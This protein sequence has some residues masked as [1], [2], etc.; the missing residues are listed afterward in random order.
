MENSQEPTTHG[1]LDFDF[2]V[3]GIYIGTNACCQDHFDSELL[4]LGIRA[5]I[6]LEEN[7]TDSPFGVDHYLWLPTID[8]NPPTQ[9]QLMHGV[10]SLRMFAEKEI[11]CYVHCKNG[12]GRAP[13]LVAAYLIADKKMEVDNAVSYIEERR[14]SVHYE[15]AQIE[16]LEEWTEGVD[17]FGKY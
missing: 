12:H 17:E 8:H 5:D 14:P 2:I 7:R 6:S 1:T 16:A 15:D 13:T 4:S 11:G 3:D 9:E 10:I